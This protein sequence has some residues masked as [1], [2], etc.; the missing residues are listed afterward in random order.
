MKQAF[1]VTLLLVSFASV[2]LAEG[3]GLPPAATTANPARPA[4]VLFADGGG[5]PPVKTTT[6]PPQA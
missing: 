3:P 6:N 2:A 1:A 4:V 5:L